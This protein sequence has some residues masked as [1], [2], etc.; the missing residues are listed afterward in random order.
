MI[1]LRFRVKREAMGLTQKEAAER[2]CVGQT[3][4]AQVETGMKMPSVMLVKLAA[5]LF[6]CTTDSLIFGDEARDSA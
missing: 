1:G 6:G 4:I 3:M 2:L 5:E